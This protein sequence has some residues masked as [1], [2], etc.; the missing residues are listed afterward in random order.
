MLNNFSGNFFTLEHIFLLSGNFYSK[1]IISIHDITWVVDKV[2]S[3]QLS[4][5]TYHL[6][7]ITYHLSL[8][9][10]HLSLITYHLSRITYHLSLITYHLSLITYHLSVSFSK[11]RS[12]STPCS[13]KYSVEEKGP[14]TEAHLCF[15]SINF[16]IVSCFYS[17]LTIT[18]YFALWLK[19]GV[20][21]LVQEVSSFRTTFD[22]F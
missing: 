15:Y 9:T 2:I 8:I 1:G 10:Y 16:A 7:L 17:C 5:I 11:W 18:A 19:K 21:K 22:V 20:G 6:S 3:Y 13:S 12:I 14:I 4:V